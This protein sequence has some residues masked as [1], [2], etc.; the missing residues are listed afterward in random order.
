METT[1]SKFDI[2]IVKLGFWDNNCYNYFYYRIVDL[3]WFY[4]TMEME[5]LV[6]ILLLFCCSRSI[7]KV[8]ILDVIL[9]VV[10]FDFPKHYYFYFILYVDLAK[11][12]KHFM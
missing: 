7:V 2:K 6:W 12:G 5:W 3:L 11:E 8:V 1:L 10:C 9:E 4:S